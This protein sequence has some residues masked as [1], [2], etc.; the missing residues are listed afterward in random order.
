MKPICIPCQ[1]FF[2]CKKNDFPF[3][4]CMPITV[5]NPADMS[6]PALESG[7]ASEVLWTP[8]KLWNGDKWE[9]EGCGAQ[10]VVGVAQRPIAEHYQPEFQ[11]YVDAI[12]PQLQVNDC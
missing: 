11:K 8:Y 3:I 1:R 6:A 9:C 7:A 12:K 5:A 10:I 2:R 4:E